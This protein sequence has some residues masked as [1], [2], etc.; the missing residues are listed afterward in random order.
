VLADPRNNLNKWENYV[1]HLLNVRETRHVR[2]MEIHITRSLL[3][4]HIAS[5][6][7]I[8]IRKWKINPSEL[9]KFLKNS[10]K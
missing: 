10:S 2:L 4:D 3:S 1:C 7:K 9:F 6:V 8:A 5:D